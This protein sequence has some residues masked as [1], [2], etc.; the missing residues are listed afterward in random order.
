MNDEASR[1]RPWYA[2]TRIKVALGIAVAECLL[3]A[4]NTD[5]SWYTIILIAIPVLLFHFFAGRNLQSARGR[6]ISWTLALSQGFALLVAI[7]SFLVGTLV[8]I[9]AGVFAAVAVY[10][11]WTD[12]PTTHQK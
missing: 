12:R 2:D 9:L 10:L 8:L 5:V 1:R 7:A 6:A 4:I 3:A 11:L